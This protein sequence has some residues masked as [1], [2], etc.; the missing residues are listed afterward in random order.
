MPV[1]TRGCRGRLC[2]PRANPGVSLVCRRSQFVPWVSSVDPRSRGGS[3]QVSVRSVHQRNTSWWPGA[4]R[5]PLCALSNGERAWLSCSSGYSSTCPR[6]K[7]EAHRCLV[8]GARDAP[9]CPGSHWDASACRGVQELALRGQATKR[10]PLVSLG[11]QETNMRAF[12]HRSL[13]WLPWGRAPTSI[14]WARREAR[15]C[16]YPTILPTLGTKSTPL[17]VLGMQR[18]P[19]CSRAPERRPWTPWGYMRRRCV[20]RTAKG[21]YC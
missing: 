6:H 19:L 2:M 5:M 10:K 9:A 15:R 18:K 12:A 17:V 7:G 1:L 11:A 14:S 16:C 21:P 3:G 20:R 4:L 13:P 8:L